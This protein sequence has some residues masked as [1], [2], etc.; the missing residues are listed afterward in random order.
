MLEVSSSFSPINAFFYPFS[1][2]F[3]ARRREDCRWMVAAKEV[4]KK[5]T[6][7]HGMRS[8]LKASQMSFFSQFLFCFPFFAL[9][10]C[11]DGIASVEAVSCWM[12]EFL[13]PRYSS[14]P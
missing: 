14:D 9:T 4:T 7:S 1:P 5:G 8:M 6:N 2:V 11:C 13:G 12:F 10:V 3:R